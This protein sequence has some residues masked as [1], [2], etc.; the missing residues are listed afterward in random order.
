[1]K[2]LSALVMTV[3]VTA[4]NQVVHIIIII[5]GYSVIVEYWQQ[6]ETIVLLKTLIDVF[7]CALTAQCS[8][9]YFVRLRRRGNLEMHE[10][11][12]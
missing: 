4:L 7:S 5:N 8:L 2:F 11:L 10:H 1:M 12:R 3:H 9:L 6:D